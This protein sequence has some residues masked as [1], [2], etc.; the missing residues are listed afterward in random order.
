MKLFNTLYA[1][2]LFIF[3]TPGLLFTISKKLSKVF[4]ALIHA[5]LFAII[6]HIT[7]TLLWDSMAIYENADTI[8]NTTKQEINPLYKPDPNNKINPN[9]PPFA[10]MCNS[11]NANQNYTN[12]DGDVCMFDGNNYKWVTPCNSDKVGFKNEKGKTCVNQ[13]NNIFNWA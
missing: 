8:T 9:G 4:I 2:I 7:R 10:V 13:G 3:F 6:F 12:S 1:T 11:S 5:L